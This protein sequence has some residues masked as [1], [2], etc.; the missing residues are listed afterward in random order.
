M[1]HWRFE[2]FENGLSGR[3]MRGCL[4]IW[5]WFARSPARYAFASRAAAAIAGIV[6]GR[7]AKLSSLPYLRGW[8]GT[9]DL[10]LPAKRSFQSQWRSGK[11]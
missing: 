10:A 2:A 9:R 6:A 3:G 7:R 4:K 1:R 11:R 8:F 5:A